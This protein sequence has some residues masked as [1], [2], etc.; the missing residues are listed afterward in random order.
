MYFMKSVS[1]LVPGDMIVWRGGSR[2]VGYSLIISVVK[3]SDRHISVGCVDVDRDQTAY[4]QTYK[5]WSL[6]GEVGVMK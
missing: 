4:I 2:V 6:D 3:T 1:K 5:G